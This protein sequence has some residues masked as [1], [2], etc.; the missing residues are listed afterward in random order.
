LNSYAER[1]VL[2]N[3]SECL[4]HVVPLGEAHLRTLVTEFVA[5][6]HLERPHQSLGN[7][8]LVARDQRVARDGVVRR[9]QRLGGMLNFYK[10]AAA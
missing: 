6:Y 3:K 5:H 9:R 10:R 8:L 2:S 7:E 4:N 1:F